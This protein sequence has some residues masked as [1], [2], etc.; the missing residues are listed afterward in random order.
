MSA[1]K[2][3]AQCSCILGVCPKDSSSATQTVLMRKSVLCHWYSGTL[4]RCAG[5]EKDTRI[6]PLQT[7]Q[8]I[9]YTR[10]VLYFSRPRRQTSWFQLVASNPHPPSTLHRRLLA[11][12][13]L[14][15]LHP[16][17]SSSTSYQHWS[18]PHTLT[19]KNKHKPHQT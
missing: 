1:I 8:L 4:I 5:L 9:K 6:F 18:Y 17:L 13:I 2:F 15:E 16:P 3:W 11:F 12:V 14:R 19:Q 7:Y 10:S